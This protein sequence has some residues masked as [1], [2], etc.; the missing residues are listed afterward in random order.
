[1]AR[2]LK[3]SNVLLAAILFGGIAGIVLRETAVGNPVADAIV[4]LS[5]FVGVTL[6]L[7][8]LKALVIPLILASVVSGITALSNWSELRRLGLMTVLYYMATTSIAVVL[9]LGF[10]LMLEP[11]AGITPGAI[12]APVAAVPAA[13]AEAPTGAAYLLRLVQETLQNPFQALAAGSPLG[14]I[15]AAIMLALAAVAVGEPARPLIKLFAA[16]NEVMMRLAH[17]IMRLAPL[18]VG[19]LTLALAAEHGLETLR[20]LLPYVSTVLVAI[21]AHILVLLAI[22]RIVARRNPLV[23]LRHMGE[24]LLLAFSTRSSAATLPVTRRCLEQKAGIPSSV[25]EFVLPVGATVNMDGTALYEGVAVMFLLQ[26]YGGMPDVHAP[27]ALVASLLIFVTAVLASVGAAAI[28][29]AGLVTMVFVAEAVGL[30]AHY[31][32]ILFPVDSFLD[33]FRTATNVLGDS[34]GAAVVAERLEI[35]PS[36]APM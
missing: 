31:L 5:S 21:A 34:I 14:V 1:M 32:V 10:V 4:S 33:M 26:L 35:P 29:N 27:T 36:T 9:G 18:G 16:L 19:C 7:G 8:L 6:F 15:F 22:L 3:E 23:F 24:A 20:V 13:A 30:P 12:S 2:R 11:G 28:P 25:S 17:W